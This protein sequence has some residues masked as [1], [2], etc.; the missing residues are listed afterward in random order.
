MKRFLEWNRELQ[1]FPLNEEFPVSSDMYSASRREISQTKSSRG[2]KSRN[3]VSVGEPAEG[4][5]S[6][7]YT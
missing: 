6:Y 3:K 5:L 7:F 1:L 2:S 4:S